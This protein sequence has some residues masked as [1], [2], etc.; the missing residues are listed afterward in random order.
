MVIR[1]VTPDY[2]LKEV[3]KLYARE[4]DPK[5]TRSIEQH[6]DFIAQFIEACGY[7]TDEYV[8]MIMGIAP[9]DNQSN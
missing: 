5:D 2:L 8:R 6:C 3:D 1:K 7:S 4:I 9:I